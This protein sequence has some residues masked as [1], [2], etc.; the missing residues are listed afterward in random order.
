LAPRD[1][2][3]LHGPRGEALVVVQQV[4]SGQWEFDLAL[5]P[6]TEPVGFWK[7]RAGTLGTV[8]T[9]SSGVLVSKPLAEAM[10]ATCGSG[11]CMVEA[12]IEHPQARV[13]AGRYFLLRPLE[14]LWIAD[15][16]CAASERPEVRYMRDAL[17]TVVVNRPLRAALERGEFTGLRF[18]EAIFFKGSEAGHST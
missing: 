15:L 13:E 9:T 12:V 14:G 16:G 17:P 3:T 18:G 1:W 10:A 5:A 4:C 11:L 2:F 8:V 6:T 7:V